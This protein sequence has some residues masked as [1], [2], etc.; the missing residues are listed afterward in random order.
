MIFQT[1]DDKSECVGIYTDGKLHFDDFPTDLTK[2][3]KY[4]GSLQNREVEYA[5]LYCKGKNLEQAAPEELLPDLV[6]AQRR[7]RAYMKSFTIAKINM[8]EHCIFDLV[9]AD[10]LKQFCEIKNQITAHVLDNCDKPLCYDHL[11]EIQKLLYKIRYQDLNINN[12]GCNNL[13]YRTRS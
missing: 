2:T 5:W 11:N 12:Q 1:L 10:F 3:W 9:P 13:F 7:F 6:K 4:T 8:R